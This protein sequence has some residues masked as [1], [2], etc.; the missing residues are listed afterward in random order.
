MNIFIF[1]LLPLLFIADKI[2]LRNK[3]FLFSFYNINVLLDP[4]NSVNAYVI[5]NNLVVTRG[6]LN[7]DIE[8][9]RAILAHEFSHMVLNH[10]KK[11]KTLLIISIVVSLLLFQINV[12]FSL[13]SLILALLFSRYLS[14]K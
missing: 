7:L 4:N 14:R 3:K 11:T 12:F 6:F 8:E 9:Q 5:G 1:A 2:A 10:Y 13:L